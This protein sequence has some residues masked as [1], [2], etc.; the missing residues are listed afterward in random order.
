MLSCYSENLLY[1]VT[2][3]FGSDAFSDNTLHMIR[4]PFSF[5]R[6]VFAGVLLF[7]TSLAAQPITPGN[8]ISLDGTTNSYA[9]VT[10]FTGFPSNAWTAE[11]WL[12]STSVL[13][14]GIFSYANNQSDNEIMFYR[15]TN[16]TVWVDGTESNPSGNIADGKW[17]HVAASWTNSGV[18]KVYVDGT[19]T[20]SQSSLRAGHKMNSG[21]ALLFGQ[22]QDAIGGGFD[23]TQAFAGDIDEVRIW[24]RVR[25]DSEIQTNRFKLLATNTVGLVAYYRFD[26]VTTDAPFSN[27]VANTNHGTIYGPVVGS[28]SGAPFYPVLVSSN[29]VSVTTNSAILTSIVYPNNV[30]TS[31]RFEWGTSTS[32][33]AFTNQLGLIG[34][35]NVPVVTTL[36]ITNL[37]TGTFYHYRLIITNSIATNIESD[38]FFPAGI[39]TVTNMVDDG[40]PGTLRRAIRSAGDGAQIFFAKTGTF[41]IT[42]G[43]MQFNGNVTVQG[44]GLS[45]SLN[46]NGASR[47]FEIPANKTVLIKDIV[48]TNGHAPNAVQ[49][50]IFSYT[51][52]SSGGAIQNSGALILSNCI[53]AG[54]SAG[55][56]AGGTFGSGN[57][58]HGG[59]L[60]NIGSATLLNCAFLTNF[61]GVGPQGGNGGVGGA[62][63]NYGSLSMSNSSF[64]GNGA[65]SGGSA[66]GNGGAGANGGA[67][68]NGGGSVTAIQCTFSGNRPGYGAGS[69]GF[70]SSGPNGTGIIE[71]VSSG[72]VLLRACTVVSNYVSGRLLNQ[73]G[74]T[75]FIVH[76]SIVAANEGGDIG[77]TFLSLGHN[78]IGVGDTGVGFTNSVNSDI[79]GTTASP[80]DAMMAPMV[81]GPG[82]TLYYHSLFAYSPAFDAGDDALL[83]LGTDQRG[84]PRK[85]FDH[86]DIG[87][88]ERYGLPPIAVTT[89]SATV[90][91][92]PVQGGAVVN[93]SGA[94]RAGT[95][96]AYA[97]F[98]YGLTTAY[99]GI[100]P[101]TLIPLG[102]NTVNFS[103]PVS[104]FA[105]GYTVHYRVIA[106]N[107]FTNAYGQDHTISIPFTSL[108]GDTNRDGV[109]SPDEFKSVVTNYVSSTPW[110][111]ITNATGLGTTNV[112]FALGTNVTTIYMVDV[113]TNLS[114][115]RPLGPALPR[116]DFLDTNAVDNV[117]R[118][119]RLRVP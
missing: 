84:G 61:A 91:S 73:T 60:E 65:G 49:V 27:A 80:I 13:N 108:P 107:A 103:I 69:F 43:A 109:I 81:P 33:Y 28:L 63:V 85:I 31:G 90:S 94:V 41:F 70:G 14:A 6:C 66:A 79:V 9:V 97:G 5:Y 88:I 2:L 76:S 106:T 116:Y 71:N 95:L 117:Q 112:T 110:L 119:Y 15:P 16:L 8:M 64:V 98:Q 35:S 87:A 74:G 72:T 105:E 34:S 92:D 4:I 47:I 100:S 30:P 55:N 3:H 20:I 29:A 111:Q 102:S 75:N 7:V 51:P 77:G 104:G 96:D 18:L 12:R 52:A 21:G 62:I 46:A 53:V 1:K 37:T 45:S 83:Y 118:Y 10:N 115:W 78:L 22:D 32:P 86:V 54:C 11:F 42:N 48:L 19:L 50:N 67:I 58:G 59:A 93:M 113:S 40:S 82:S 23:P 101:V 57:A 89:L 36:Q 56:G 68:H 24:D 25:N 17:H 26:E 114:D 39:F 44:P 99:G 38:Q